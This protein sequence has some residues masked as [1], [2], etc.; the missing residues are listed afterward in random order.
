[1]VESDHYPK[2]TDCNDCP[3]FHVRIVKTSRKQPQA[4]KSPESDVKKV[5]SIKFPTI[6]TT[7]GY[8]PGEEEYPDLKHTDIFRTVPMKKSKKLDK[9]RRPQLTLQQLFQSE[10]KNVILLG[11]PGHGKTEEG[12]LFSI[13]E[14]NGSQKRYILS[15]I[16]GKGGGYTQQQKF[17]KFSR[18][19]TGGELKYQLYH[20]D[21]AEQKPLI[22]KGDRPYSMLG[23]T[24]LTYIGTL[25]HFITHPIGD[26]QTAKYESDDPEW[27]RTLLKPHFIFIDEVDS[28]SVSI[29][30]FLI[31]IIRVFKWFN[32]FVKVILASATLGNPHEI[33]KRFFGP[34]EQYEIVKGTGR[35]GPLTIRIHYEDKSKEIL[36][37]KLQ[38]WNTDMEVE[39]T[40]YAQVDNYTPKKRFFFFDHKIAHNFLQA[41]KKISQHFG[42]CHGWLNFDEI[43]QIAKQFRA[44]PMMM[45]LATTSMLLTSFDTPNINRSLWYGIPQ[46]PRDNV[47]LL[48]RINRNPN[49]QGEIDII[50]RA[51][52]SYEAQLTQPEKF[53][54]FLKLLSQPPDIPRIQPWFTTETL[55]LTILWGLLVGMTVGYSDGFSEV[56]NHIKDDFLHFKDQ[57]FLQQQLQTVCWELGVEGYINYNDDGKLV[58]TQMTKE[59]IFERVRIEE[60]PSYNVIV[61]RG[62][63]K[64]KLGTIEYQNLIRHCLV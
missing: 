34:E 47:Q 35:R 44:D 14:V 2:V 12:M 43:V 38:E 10:D 51:F 29:M 33:A 27:A 62:N 31:P 49:Q 20:R 39:A 59:W 8:G 61:Q 4:E 40:R 32:P 16:T 28:F 58:P 22:R 54:E 63:K 6:I 64:K 26:Q 3:S 60:N 19:L 15:F 55:K 18:M 48:G 57:E 42:I 25:T 41:T 52:N 17:N 53:E 24:P 46:T 9:L 45:G 11:D 13:D 50:L 5:R 56:L 23:I 30:G 21:L 1:M 36:Y 7:A 37:Q